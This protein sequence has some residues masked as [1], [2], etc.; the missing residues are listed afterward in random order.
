LTP[1]QILFGQLLLL[2]SLF[3]FLCSSFFRL[4]NQFFFWTDILT[5]LG[6]VTVEGQGVGE[7]EA[8]KEETDTSSV[9]RD[10][11]KAEDV[12]W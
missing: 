1:G 11:R 5:D 9:K 6:D 12:S 2:C 7:V 10:Y 4:K 8:I 3:F